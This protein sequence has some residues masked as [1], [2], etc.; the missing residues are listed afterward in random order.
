MTKYR[1]KNPEVEHAVRSCYKTQDA[2]ERALQEWEETFY[3]SIEHGRS[4]VAA[5]VTVNEKDSITGAQFQIRIA[6]S[7]LERIKNAEGE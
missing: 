6:L 3:F 5:L 2:F 4:K 1:I 7:E